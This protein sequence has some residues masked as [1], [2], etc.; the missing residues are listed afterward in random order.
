MK[1]SD[2][3]RANIDPIL[4]AWEKFAGEISAGR[5]L[6]IGTLRDH[7]VGILHTIAS[8]LDRPQSPQEE[9]AKSTGHGPRLLLTTEAEMHGATRVMAGFSLDNAMAEFRALRASVLRLWTKARQ[10]VQPGDA[11]DITRFNESIDQALSESIGRFSDEKDRYTRLF[12]ALLSSSPDLHFIFRADGA[13]VYA[14]KS[15]SRL[16]GMSTAEIISRNLFDICSVGAQE[17]RGLVDHLIAT[18][19]LYQGDIPCIPSASDIAATYE[20]LLIPVFDE[21]GNFEAIAATARDVSERK[22]MEDRI[23]RNANYDSLTG[24]PNRRLFRDRLEREVKRSARADVP[25][26]LLFIDLDGFKDVNDRLGHAAGDQLLQQA[27]QRIRHCVREVDTVARLGGDEFTVILTEVTRTA[28]VEIL[29]QQILAELAKPFSVLDSDVQVSGSMG[30]TLCPQDG[31]T[32]DELLK[33]AD[34]AMYA[35]KAAGRNRFGFFTLEMRN[36]AWARLRVI[37]ELRN[38]L[39]DRRLFLH[40]QPIVDLASDRIVKAEAQLRW[41]HPD[42]GLMSAEAFIGLAEETGLIGEIGVWVHSE[43]LAHAH[44][45]CALSGASFQVS[46]H[47]SATELM[48]KGPLEPAPA[49]PGGGLLIEIKEEVLLH[50]SPAMRSTLELLRQEGGELA[51]DDFGVGCAAMGQLKKFK[52]HYLKIDRSFIH[53]VTNQTESRMFVD[54]IIAMAHKLGLKVIAEGVETAGQKDWLKTAGCDMAQGYY[55]SAPVTPDDFEQLL[56]AEAARAGAEAC[57]RA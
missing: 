19:I 43:A 9:L 39:A 41:L 7:A 27:A 49:P 31:G 55:F 32:P 20:G 46:I 2:F 34:Q 53:A 57:R 29:A 40:Y 15:F 38:A 25:C 36:A 52:V 26:A 14:N 48:I 18:R 42:S 56:L 8:D 23:K 16:Y 6:E 21:A 30:I 11:E 13:I 17:L 1:R 33:N 37:D 51:I 47:K 10:E 44:K 12:D 3:I 28:H 24:L 22:A 4:D 45:W 54:S 50:S 35:A 5:N